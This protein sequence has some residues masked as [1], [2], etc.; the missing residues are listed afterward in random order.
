MAMMQNANR[1]P[2]YKVQ[3]FLE[4]NGFTRVATRN[5][6]YV[7]I[8]QTILGGMETH[9]RRMNVDHRI[10]VPSSHVFKK[11]ESSV[12]LYFD[13]DPNMDNEWLVKILC[14][15]NETEKKLKP[16]LE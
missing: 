3:E 9:V 5:P 8:K 15:C 10:G 6:P 12:E 7:E 11:G 2:L 16:M 14:T 4:K 1:T 13:W